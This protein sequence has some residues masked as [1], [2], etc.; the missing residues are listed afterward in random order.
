MKLQKNKKKEKTAIKPVAVVQQEAMPAVVDTNHGPQPCVI[1]RDDVNVTI[2]TLEG[3]A[4]LKDEW[5]APKMAVATGYQED[6]SINLSIVDQTTFPSYMLGYSAQHGC[7]ECVDLLK[8]ADSA[9]AA[10]AIDSTRMV[11]FSAF[12]A[13]INSV[14]MVAMYQAKKVITDELAKYSP[15]LYKQVV[16][17]TSDNDV[18]K[19]KY[20][21][22]TPIYPGDVSTSCSNGGLHSIGNFVAG[23]EP[24]NANIEAIKKSISMWID[25]Y[26]IKEYEN[27]M[28]IIMANVYNTPSLDIVEADTIYA[29]VEEYAADV[30]KCYATPIHNSLDGFVQDLIFSQ[31]CSF[32]TAK[33]RNYYDF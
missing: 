28:Q 1:F 16:K 22:T 33:V 14:I 13:K 26:I 4:S 30:F 15:D 29:T 7:A 8:E 27:I 20:G 3:Y 19:S 21:V 18:L 32:P 25:R 9:V 23:C 31:I 10:V 11:I 5:S 24:S 2:P 12:A 6:G 17:A